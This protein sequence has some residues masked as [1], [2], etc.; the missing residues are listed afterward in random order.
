MYRTLAAN[1]DVLAYETYFNN[2]EA[3]NVHSS[4]LNPNENPNGAAAYA[5][6]W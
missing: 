5:S 1:R 3:N 2:S 4:L 6:L